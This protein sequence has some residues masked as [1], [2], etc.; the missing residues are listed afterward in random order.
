[1]NIYPLDA[2]ILKS[3]EHSDKWLAGGFHDCMA[4]LEKHLA[5]RPDWDEGEN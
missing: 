4:H 3:S 1:M 2:A 5:Y